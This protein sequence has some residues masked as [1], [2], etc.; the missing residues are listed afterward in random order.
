MFHRAFCA[1]FIAGILLYPG[2][3]R[4][5]GGELEVHFSMGN[6]LDQVRNAYVSYDAATT[7]PLSYVPRF[8]GQLRYGLSNVVDVVVGGEF[9]LPK[10]VAVRDARRAPGASVNLVS[11]YRDFVL[12]MGLLLHRRRGTDLGWALGLQSG[13]MWTEWSN[14]E[15][16]EA[17]AEKGT[18]GSAL[19][20]GN[21]SNS[22]MDPFVGA[23]LQMRWRPWDML[24]MEVGPYARYRMGG[25]YYAGVGFGFGL[26]GS[27]GPSF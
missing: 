24:A 11:T 9:S 10:S 27:A 4:A 19:Y 2:I 25:D 16:R 1:V 6:E 20:T 23:S 14:F 26:V 3:G 13:F 7:D 17:T 22:A 5:D 18:E 15:M 8:S 21:A 12:P